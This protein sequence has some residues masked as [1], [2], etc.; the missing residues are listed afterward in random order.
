MK[1]V[2]DL[3]GCSSCTGDGP[4]IEADEKFAATKKRLVDMLTCQLEVYG[5]E[6]HALRV[7]ME[8]EVKEKMHSRQA[9]G[10]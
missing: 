9:R 1:G 5:K 8:E 3:G 10:D 4:P 7:L 2:C 6:E